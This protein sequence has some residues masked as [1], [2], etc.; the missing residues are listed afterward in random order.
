MALLYVN[1]TR[2]YT[3]NEEIE[4]DMKNCYIEGTYGSYLDICVKPG[5]ERLVRINK[6]EGVNDY[7]V[8]IVKLYYKIVPS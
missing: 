7:H 8:K 1:N 2:N 4:F 5:N 6:N 3:I